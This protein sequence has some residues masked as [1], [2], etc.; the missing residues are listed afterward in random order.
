MTRRLSEIAEQLLN[1]SEAD[2][3]CGYDPFDG[4]NSKVFERF[5]FVKDSLFGLAWTQLFKRSPI[6][7]RR[8]L[9]VPKRRNPKGAG[10]FILGLVIDYRLSKDSSY[11]EKAI[12]LADWLLEI[13]CDKHTWQYAC[14]GYHFDWK[15]R[16]FFVPKGKPNVITTIYVS[17]A[18][19]ELS[20]EID[21]I[22]KTKA[23]LYRKYA[24]DSASFIVNSLFTQHEGKTFFAYIPGETAFV[25]NASLWAAAWVAFVGS[26]TNNVKYTELSIIVARQSVS[27]QK[28]DGS[29]TYGNRSHHQ[30]IDG[31]HTGY[32]LEALDLIRRSVDTQ[33]FD[34]PIKKGFEFY[35]VNL[36]EADG[37]AKYY[38]NNRYPLDPHCVSQAIITI[39][40]IGG[41]VEDL[42]LVEKVISCSIQSLYL[43][44]SGQFVYQ[45]MAK[46]VNKINYM[47]WT[48]AW[49]YFSLNYYLEFMEN[50]NETN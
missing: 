39:L 46:S 29:W 15:A 9:A 38:H 31:F 32:N 6:N 30:F 26:Q 13:Q 47:R 23:M 1:K 42:E 28:H 2:N 25:H 22:D 44:D 18:L 43:S 50:Q 5:P 10:L 4:L 36:F 48:Q 11:L 12:E 40:K 7:F 35:K 20:K 16:A 8:I 41:K 27:E 17:Q 45:K 21:N 14:W 49:M 3:Y 24:F 19:Y 37:T 33:E 34:I